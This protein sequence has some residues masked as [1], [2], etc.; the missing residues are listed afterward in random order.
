MRD[1]VAGSFHLAGT[2]KMGNDAMAVV[3]SNL[4]VHDIKG[5]QVADAFDCILEHECNFDCDWWEGHRHNPGETA[6][7]SG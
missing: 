6:V 4:K 5:L 2:C 1:N 3:D 7:A